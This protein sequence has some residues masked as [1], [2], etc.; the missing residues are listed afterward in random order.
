M[1]DKIV[2]IIV[3]LA[4]PVVLTLSIWILGKCYKKK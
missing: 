4:I 2:L 1:N 3:I